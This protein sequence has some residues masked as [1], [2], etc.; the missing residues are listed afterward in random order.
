MYQTQHRWI[1]CYRRECRWWYP[2][3]EL[4]SNFLFSFSSFYHNGTNMMAETRALRDGFNLCSDKG[5]QVNDIESYSKVMVDSILGLI[6][7]PLHVLYLI[8]ECIGLLS[9]GMMVSHIYRQGNS[10]ADRLA[11]HAYSHRSD[12][13][14]EA[15]SSLLQTSLLQ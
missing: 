6:S 15:A 13:I 2:E 1:S 14:V 9:S 8:R 3:K 12:C 7:T 10:I 11:S 4:R 5:I